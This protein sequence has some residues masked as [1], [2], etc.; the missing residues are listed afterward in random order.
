MLGGGA[1]LIVVGVAEVIDHPVRPVRPVG[2]DEEEAELDVAQLDL[3]DGIVVDAAAA[4]Y[5][6]P[7][8]LSPP[9]RSTVR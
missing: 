6:V 4:P 5:A 2:T 3:R 9:T 1:P 7:V 8:P